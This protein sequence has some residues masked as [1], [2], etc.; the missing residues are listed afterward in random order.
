[1]SE[2]GWD[3]YLARVRTLNRDE[4]E[5]VLEYK[6]VA[7]QYLRSEV[8]DEVLSSNDNWIRAAKPKFQPISGEKVS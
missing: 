7:E 3:A 5:S 8:T 1:M 2:A 6:R 4:V